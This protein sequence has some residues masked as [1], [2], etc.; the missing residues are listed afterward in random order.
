MCKPEEP[1]NFRPIALTSCVGKVFTS[2]LKNR[3]LE[4]MLANRFLNTNIQKAFMRNIPGCTE[5]FYKLLGAIQESKQKH[6]SITVCWLDLANAYGSVHHDLI[7]FTL[8]HYHAPSCFRDVVASLYS[9]L[10][11][12]VTTQ[13][14]TTNPIPLQ[15]GVYQGDPLSVIIFNTVMATLA[16]S[17]D[18]QQHLGYKF[19]KSSRSTNILQY[20]DDTCLIA[21]GPSSCQQLLNCVERWLQW[22]GMKAKVPKCHS[23]AIQASSGKTYDPSLMLQGE[24]IPSIGNNAIKFLGAFIQV[25]KNSNQTREDLHLKLTSLLDKVDTVP[26]TRNQKLLLYRAAICPRILWDLGISDLPF[27]WI[28][29]C[30]EATAT[31]YLKRWSG[32]ARS[33]DPSRLYLPKPNGGLDLPSISGLYQKI[34]VSHACQLLT[35]QDPITQ[36]VAKLRIQKEENQQ[37]LQFK[38][39]LVA[40]EVMVA[41]PGASRKALTGQVK[42]AVKAVE[43]AERL[44]HAKGLSSQGELHHLVE[45]DAATLWSE[46]VQQLPPDCLK[47]ALN[48]AQDTLPHNANL[49]VWRRK[50]GLSSQCKLCGGRQTLLHVLN[51][52]KAAL[53]LRRYN[54]RHDS[55]LQVIADFVRDHLPESFEMSADLPDLP[56][57]FPLMITPTDLRPDI[58]LWSQT[59][60][61]A[62]LVELTVCYETNYVQAQTRKSDKYQDLVDAGEANGFTMEV[63]TLEV[64]SRGF[65]NLQGFKA[66]FQT[67]TRCPRK[68]TWN[69]LKTI[70]RITILQSQR[71]WTTR[72]IIT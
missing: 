56:Y 4:Y 72:N 32:L 7:D 59:L 50:E 51:H 64:G 69:F 9:N 31:R 49:A 67:L 55:V 27:S 43:M 38:P 25:P 21:D 65:L 18:H 52:C 3:W 8:Q 63:I 39:M 19:S 17:I 68:N 37:R 33:A 53:E 13:S 62:T 22:S 28:K 61:L 40:R 47:F 5:Q 23:L 2:I 30:L 44:D 29:S 70:C 1:G 11:A 6:K 41:D 60:Q 42:K 26:V 54:T 71:I 16:D 20:A 66:L 45:N 46:T 12:V 24:R 36:H 57:N 10:S 14:W 48:S 58:V 34:H 15:I 35:S